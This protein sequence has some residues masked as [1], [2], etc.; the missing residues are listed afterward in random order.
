[1]FVAPVRMGGGAK[2]NVLQALAAGTPVVGTAPCFAGF[3]AVPPGGVVCN[4][5]DDFVSVIEQLLGDQPKLAAVSADARA[6]ALTEYTWCASATRLL[7][8]VKDSA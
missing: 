5:D 2:N 7:A 6:F 8:H 3:D 1:L 4:S